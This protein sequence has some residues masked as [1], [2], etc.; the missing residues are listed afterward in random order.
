M[1]VDDTPAATQD[2]VPY[3]T[4]RSIMMGDAHRR[5]SPQS[6]EGLG[7]SLHSSGS[8]RS[9]RTGGLDISTSSQRQSQ[10]AVQRGRS[11]TDEEA[12]AQSV[13]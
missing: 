3:I 9:G 13:A 7:D 10:I 8:E 1:A 6:Q 2:E 4:G 12:L 5:G 11:R